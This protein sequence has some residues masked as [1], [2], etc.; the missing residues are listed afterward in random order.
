MKFQKIS[1]TK[2]IGMCVLAFSLVFVPVAF[3]ADPGAQGNPGPAGTEGLTEMQIAAL[4][5]ATIAGVA[6]LV[7]SLSD[8]DAKPTAQHVPK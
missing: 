5:A 6:I 1:L 7:T 8:G 2:K 3:G 4:A